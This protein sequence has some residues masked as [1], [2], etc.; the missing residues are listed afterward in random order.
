MSLPLEPQ[1]RIFGLPAPQGIA[2]RLFD[3][4]VALALFLALFWLLGLLM[5]VA[6]LDT[7]RSG[8]FRQQRLG[9]WGEPFILFKIRTMRPDATIDTNVTTAHDP[10]ITRIGSFLRRTKLD[11]LPQLVN[12]LLGEMSFVGPR[13]DVPEAYQGLA[14]ADRR[15]FTIR[16]GMTGPAS[17]AFS[18]EEDDLA[19]SDDPEAY[20][21]DV[22]F[23]EKIR[24]NLAYI[25]GQGFWNDIRILVSTLF[26]QLNRLVH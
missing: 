15:I 1:E 10:R 12:I 22:I 18:R 16:P 17:L 20:N 7:G 5:L 25:D 3:F 13:P 21:R 14:G 19:N 23:P 8:I 4:F 11:E 9:L 6:H 2:K 24:I 26:G